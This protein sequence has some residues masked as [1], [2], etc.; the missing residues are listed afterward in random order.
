MRYSHCFV[1]WSS[2]TDPVFIK[3][4]RSACLVLK[5]VLRLKLFPMRLHFS[6]I[7]L[8]YG[9]EREYC[10]WRRTLSGR[11]PH[12]VVN[13][14]FSV[15]IKHQIMSYVFNFVVENLLILT[16]DLRSAD[17]TM[18]DPPFN[19][20]WV[21]GLEVQMTSGMSR[22]LVHF[23][24]LFW[25]S[26][27]NQNVQERKGVISF[28]ASTSIVN[29]MVG[30]TLLR[31]WRNCCNLACPRGQTT[32]L[33]TY[34]SHLADLGSAVSTAISSEFSINMLLNPGDSEFPTAILSFCW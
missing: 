16:Y 2:L 17:Q 11:W 34:L 23:R 24:G 21:V 30:L 27:R 14:F 29:S 28:I 5:M 20:I 10:V 1:C 12:Y 22:L 4:P 15:F 13:E 25:T 18:N 19:A 32:N 9:I 33:S 31:W 26:L 7:P 6:E 8:T 3:V